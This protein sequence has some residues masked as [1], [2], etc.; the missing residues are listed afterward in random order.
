MNLQESSFNQKAFVQISDIL[1]PPIQCTIPNRH[2]IEKFAEIAKNDP[3][4]LPTIKIGQINNKLYAI[5]NLDVLQSCKK[6]NVIE[7]IPVEIT[8]YFSLSEVIIEHLNESIN[9]QLLNPLS[10]FDAIDI[11][12]EKGIDKNHILEKIWLNDTPYEKIL[13]LQDSYISNKS[14]EQLQNIINKLSERRLPISAIQIPIYVIIKIS[15]IEKEEH[16]FT[17]INQI[18]IMLSNIPNGKF[19]WPTPEQV[20][21]LYSFIK[22]SDHNREE[23]TEEEDKKESKSKKKGKE[24]TKSEEKENQDEDND[25]N[26]Y[27]I[28]QSV[29]NHLNSPDI[30]HKNFD[31]TRDLRY[32]IKKLERRKNV[33]MTLLWS[34]C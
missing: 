28:P 9:E 10:L 29:L 31:S 6:I 4:S 14:V 21:T 22:S 5:N 11:L 27:S 26:Q 25:H 24:K 3:V 34:Y 18:D 32:F 33:K 30:R 8:N 13:K 16:Q 17:L 12:Q 23:E 7:Q 1:L 2:M 20:D 19:A 15:R